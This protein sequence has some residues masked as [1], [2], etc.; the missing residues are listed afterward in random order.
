MAVVDTITTMGER[1]SPSEPE[2]LAGI[3]TASLAGALG[4]RLVGIPR[5]WRSIRGGTSGS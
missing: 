1:P 4:Q 3:P 5:G 2:E